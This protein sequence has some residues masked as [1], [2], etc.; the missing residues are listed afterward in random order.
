MNNPFNLSD[1]ELI[2][3][4]KELRIDV[5]KMLEKSQSGHTGGAL[6]MADI[7]AAIYFKFLRYD[8]QDVKN[9]ERDRFYL[10]NGHIC[11]IMYAA[12]ANAGYFPKEELLTFR[13]IN[14]RLQGHP[15][16]HMLPGIENSSGPLGQGVSQAVGAALRAKIDHKDYKVICVLSDGEHQEGQPWEAFLFAKKNKLDNLFFIVD[17]NDIE[18]DGFLHNIL[19][20]EPLDKKHEAFGLIPSHVQGNNIQDITYVLD[21]AFNAPKEGSSHIVIAHTILG[22]GVPFMENNYDWHGK[23]PNHEEAQQALTYLQQD[24]G[25]E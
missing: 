10:S 1:Q 9:D 13:Q 21:K 23:A 18:I 17:D 22:Y 12:M 19:P 7:F 2:Q 11:P 15:S 25:M 8:P 14:S 6:G 3:K 16:N 5:I 20:V 4:A 24:Y